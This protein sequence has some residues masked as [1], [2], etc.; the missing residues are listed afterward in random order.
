MTN[1]EFVLY[2]Q[3]KTT[4]RKLKS[5]IITKF[6]TG[7]T[8]PIKPSLTQNDPPDRLTIYGIVTNGEG[9][10]FYRLADGVVSESLLHLKVLEAEFTGKVKCV[11]IN[12]SLI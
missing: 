11:F 3:Q 1:G 8:M 10:K 12:L 2:G 6:S 5:L 4:P 7:F 9:W